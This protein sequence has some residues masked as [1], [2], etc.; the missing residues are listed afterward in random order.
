M[1]EYRFI[2][3]EGWTLWRKEENGFNNSTSRE[4]FWH[5]M[6]NVIL[7]KLA[8]VLVFIKVTNNGI[9][10]KENWRYSWFLP[11]DEDDNWRRRYQAWCSLGVFVFFSDREKNYV[12]FITFLHIRM[13]V[14]F[15]EAGVKWWFACLFTQFGNEICISGSNWVFA[16]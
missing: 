2:Q 4:N 13:H 10:I 11:D 14:L 3:D 8:N 15:E 16:T 12:F 1:V 9:L 7:I 5:S 6:Q